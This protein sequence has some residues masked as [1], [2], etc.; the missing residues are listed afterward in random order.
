MTVSKDFM[1]FI[2]EGDEEIANFTL[3]VCPCY[4]IG[5]TLFYKVV[6]EDDKFWNVEPVEKTKFRII[7]IEQELKSIYTRAGNCIHCSYVILYVEKEI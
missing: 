5:Q 1:I 3:D 7:G 2:M 4:Q 6:N